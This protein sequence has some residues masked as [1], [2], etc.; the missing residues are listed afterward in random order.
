MT[1][2]KT[3]LKREIL[4][5]IQNA[6]EQTDIGIPINVVITYIS[7]K[8]FSDVTCTREDVMSIIEILYGEGKVSY[9]KADVTLPIEMTQ[10]FPDIY[11][12]SRVLLVKAKA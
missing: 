9:H 4:D 8:P 11:I 10:E 1:D 12:P 3:V 5:F 6:D 7:N 2:Y